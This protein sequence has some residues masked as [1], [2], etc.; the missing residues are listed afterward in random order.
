MPTSKEIANMG[1]GKIGAS[2]INNLA[3]PVS[4]LEILIAGQYDQW[5]RSE[6]AKRRWVFATI[7]ATL[8]PLPGTE[9]DLGDG[10]IYKYNLPG[11]F[12]RPVRNN[13]SSWV[14]NGQFIYDSDST[15]TLEYIQSVADSELTDPLFVDVL[16]CRIA[17]ECAEPATQSPGKK[18]EAVLMYKDALAEA[19]RSN[20]FILD[21]D[22]PVS[23]DDNGYSWVVERLYP[24]A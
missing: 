11:A 20:A 2:R 12:L 4:P 5:K 19:G 16:A 24:N 3:P 21:N 10:R 13:A 17:M 22:N 23:D 9:T 15:L 18:R 14:Q 8:T 1:L 6:L 7:R